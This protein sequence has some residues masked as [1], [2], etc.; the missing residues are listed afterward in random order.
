[1]N[2]GKDYVS[3]TLFKKLQQHVHKDAS[4]RQK[5]NDQNVRHEQKNDLCVCIR[6]A[7]FTIRTTIRLF[8]ILRG[9]PTAQMEYATHTP[10]AHREKRVVHKWL[11]SEN[12]RPERI[13]NG[14]GSVSAVRGANVV[15][16]KPM[17][18]VIAIVASEHTPRA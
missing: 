12:R 10:E 2:S 7:A 8:R 11:T 14:P 15:W 18:V 9:Q 17:Q 16:N 4:A 1:V 13:A 6:G 3:A 5:C